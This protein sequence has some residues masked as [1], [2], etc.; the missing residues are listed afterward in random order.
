VNNTSV[1]EQKIGHGD[2]IRVGTYEYKVF[3]DQ[4]VVGTQTEYHLPEE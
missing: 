1:K 2:F 4:S 3:D